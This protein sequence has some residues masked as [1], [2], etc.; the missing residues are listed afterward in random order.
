ML[1]C[2]SLTQH[3]TNPAGTATTPSPRTRWTRLDAGSDDTELAIAAA[4][5]DE[6]ALELLLLRHYDRVHAVVRRVVRNAADVEEAR[7]DALLA[8]ARGIHSFDGRARFTTWLHRVATN[9]ALMH[10][11]KHRRDPEPVERLPERV[12]SIGPERIVVGRLALDDALDQ[13]AP[14]FREAVLLAD[15]AEL[16]YQEIAGRL[17]VPIGTVRSRVNRGR[18][19]LAE[20]LQG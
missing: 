14:E 19:K 12:E 13:L 9:A 4:G 15:Q 5:G 2:M 20:L 18:A 17:G 6:R 8:V 1:R 11:R 10:L 16:E 3:S 7:Q